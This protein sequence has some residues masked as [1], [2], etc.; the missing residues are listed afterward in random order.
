MIQQQQQQQQL[1]LY[2]NSTQHKHTTHK[3]ALYTHNTVH[4]FVHTQHNTSMVNKL[5]KQTTQTHTMQH[6]CGNK[7]THTAQNTQ[8]KYIQYALGIQNIADRK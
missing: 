1:C 3:H 2:C 6:K 5:D 8:H 4:N 7:K